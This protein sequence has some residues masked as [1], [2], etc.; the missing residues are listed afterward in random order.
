MADSYDDLREYR[1]IPITT[2]LRFRKMDLPEESEQVIEKVVTNVSGGGIFVPG[3]AAY[4]K[5]ALLQMEF[6]IP[7]KQGTVVVMGRVVWAGA[8][9]MGVEFLKIDARVK[10]EIIKNARRGA[11]VESSP[12]LPQVKLSSAETGDA[13]PM[14]EAPPPPEESDGFASPPPREAPPPGDDPFKF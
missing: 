10:A 9:G 11:W 6:R 5:G 3:Q 1:R 13:P 2:K 7:S 14:D 12:D 8:Q 4:E